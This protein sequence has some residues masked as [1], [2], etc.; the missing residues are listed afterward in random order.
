MSDILYVFCIVASTTRYLSTSL[1]SAWS[2]QP[3]TDLA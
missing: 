1:S 3:N 2:S